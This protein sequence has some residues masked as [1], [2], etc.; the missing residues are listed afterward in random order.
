M[1]QLQPDT[2]IH[3]EDEMLEDLSEFHDPYVPKK[4]NDELVHRGK[5]NVTKFIE[6]SEVKMR[7]GVF[8]LLG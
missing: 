5:E 2:I 8:T 7:K 6:E 4:R 1:Q 3:V